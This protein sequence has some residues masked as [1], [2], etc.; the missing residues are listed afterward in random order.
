MRVRL[1]Y[2]DFEKENTSIRVGQDWN[3]IASL[4]PTTLD[5]GIMGYNGNLWGRIPQVTLSQKLGKGF[6]GNF[7][8][9]R[10]R[11]GDDDDT[12]GSHTNDV[13][14]RMPW[15]GG[16]LTYTGKVLDPN[17]NAYL[18][19][20]GAFRKGTVNDNDVTPYVASCA[21]RIPYS[22]FELTGET[23]IGQ[24]LGL[25]YFRKG[26][27]F[28]DSGNAILTRG[29]FVQLS[30]NPWKPIKFHLGYGLDDPKDADVG[31]EFYQQSQYLFGNVIV[32]VM[33]D[34]SAG[35]EINYV[36]TQWATT[37]KQDGTRYSS[38]LIYTW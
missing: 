3:K 6:V 33:K 30:A 14:I 34:I 28:N 20:S 38:S 36:E 37:G 10:Y 26:G 18:E 1:A 11:W 16:S 24:G 7:T 17:K 12:F 8:I 2:V 31:T 29:G 5:F 19:L 25:D 35:L 22:I 9:Y 23:Y 27:A 32:Q 15:V 13:S 21:L 4:N